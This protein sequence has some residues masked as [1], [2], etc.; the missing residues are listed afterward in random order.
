MN[1]RIVTIG[2]LRLGVTALPN[3]SHLIRVLD[4][5]TDAYH[6][7]IVASEMDE[8][9]RLF[10]QGWI[11]EPLSRSQWRAAGATL[12][13]DAREVVFERREGDAVR[14]VRLTL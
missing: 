5:D 9:S 8:G 3:L 7:M 1:H 12:F 2:D 10:L 6:R 13:P 4:G 14:M 11:G